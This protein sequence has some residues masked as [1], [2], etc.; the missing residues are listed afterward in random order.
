MKNLSMLSFAAV[1][2]LSLQLFAQESKRT[3]SED[4]QAVP[5]KRTQGD[6]WTRALKDRAQRGTLH[7][8]FQN[9]RGDTGKWNDNPILQHVPPIERKPPKKSLDDWADQWLEQD[10]QLTNH[11]N[12]WLI[13]R[14]RQLDDNDRV[15][16]ER[17]ERNGNAFTVAVSEA[18]WQGRYSKTFTYYSVF[19]LNLGKLEAGT[20]E[21]KWIIHPLTFKQFEGDGRPTD[22][23]PKDEQAVVAR[24]GDPSQREGDPSQRI[25]RKPTELR[26]T[27]KVSAK[28]P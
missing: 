19:G 18:I 4:S 21:V 2:V 5:A 27:F 24:S 1:L 7:D 11:D 9:V 14:T 13:L 25:D 23:W 28:E 16:V 3:K 26:L 22:H 15:W 12:S 17:I 20:Y 8:A 10:F 6:S